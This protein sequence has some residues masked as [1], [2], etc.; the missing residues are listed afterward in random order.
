MKDKQTT[1]F[2]LIIGILCVNLLVNNH[3]I[4][5]WDEDE[6]A[7]ASFAERMYEG[8]SWVNPEYKWSRV[9][10][11]IPLHFW[12]ITCSYYLFGVNEF[13]V[14]FPGALAIL[15]TCLSV[16]FL[17]RSVF[18]ESM[19][20]W[21]AI[22]LATSIIFPIMG[23]VGLTDATLL[24][25][26]T[27]AVLALLNFILLPQWK[28]L[29]LLWGGVALGVMTKGPPILILVG[30]LWIWLAIFHSQRK[31]LIKTHPW[32]FGVLAML[33]FAAWVYLS[34]QEDYATWQASGMSIPFEEWWQ[35]SFEERKIHVLPFL[36][37]W[38]ILKRVGGSVLGQTAPPGF[39]LGI[40][41]AAFLTWLPF[42]LP[43]IWNLGRNFFKKDRSSETIMLAGWLVFAWLFFELM[44]SKSVSYTLAVQPAIALLI[45]Q[46]LASWKTKTP[47]PYQKIFIGGTIL[48]S[49]ILAVLVFALPVFVYYFLGNVGWWRTLLFS[50]LL[51]SSLIYLL[52]QLKKDKEKAAR[53]FAYVGAT[54]MFLLW[55]L[56]APIAEQTPIKSLKKVAEVALSL[57]KNKKAG[58]KSKIPV[59]VLGPNVKQSKISLLFYLG[60]SFETCEDP[61]WTVAVDRYMSKE[62]VILV[63]GLSAIKTIDILLKERGIKG[64]LNAVKKQEVDFWS[65]DDQLRSN[66]YL[67]LTNQ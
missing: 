12:T 49:I 25:S 22:I 24:L 11:K 36:W 21:A 42:V 27:I 64:G 41:L 10:R 63:L 54:L 46:Q 55:F 28:W 13:A 48:Y 4:T 33:P 15:L 56:V 9:H 66:P 18:G 2:W 32:I 30:G 60:S 23:K 34:Y 45:A 8:E 47:Y 38:Y 31:N 44:T 40:I 37:D 51:G 67:I 35:E 5:L 20:R 61:I 62:P 53:A 26:Q 59:Y 14:R 3:S 65:L 39:H 52:I 58:E 43:A 50:I 17:G 7:Y 6:A 1:F 57:D 19:A 29:L 16:F